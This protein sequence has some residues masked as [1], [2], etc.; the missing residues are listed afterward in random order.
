M[1]TEQEISYARKKLV[2]TLETVRLNPEQ[3]AIIQGMSVALQWVC[4][5]HL[6]INVLQAILDGEPISETQEVKRGEEKDRARAR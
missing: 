6:P 4:E 5:H 2:V 1:K 3:T